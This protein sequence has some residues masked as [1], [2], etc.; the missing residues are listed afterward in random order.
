MEQPKHKKLKY[1][2]ITFFTIFIFFI[3]FVIYRVQTEKARFR[4]EGIRV[5]ANVN[6]MYVSGTNKSKNYTM[7][8]SMFTK[9]NEPKPVK[10]DTTGKTASQI[11]FDQ[12]LDKL[13][14][15][16]NIGSYMSLTIPINSDSYNKYKPGDRVEVVYLKE[17][18]TNVKLWSEVE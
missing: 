17:D 10:S 9:G 13:T 7:S 11:K 5:N 12:I 6:G 4:N 18:S 16:S 14:I 15:N 8:I 3:G 1:F 2:L